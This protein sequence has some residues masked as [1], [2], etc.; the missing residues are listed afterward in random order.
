MDTNYNVD[1]IL[2][3]ALYSTEKP[4]DELINNIKNRYARE[5]SAAKNAGM[6]RPLRFVTAII[7]ALLVTSVTALAVGTYLGGFDRLRE[8]LG[9]EQVDKLHAVEKS[10][11]IGE[12]LTE[13]G[14]RIE[15][16]AVGVDS[17]AIDFYFTL[18]DLISNRLDGDIWINATVFPVVDDIPWGTHIMFPEV[19]D[20]SVDGVVTL[21]GR[22]E[23]AQPIVGQELQF[24]IYDISYN[25]KSG[26]YDT[27]IDLAS[28]EYFAP[29]AWYH[30]MPILPPNQYIIKPEVE[31]IETGWY[32]HISSIG[33]IEGQ[34]HIQQYSDASL[35][36]PPDSVDF[37]LIDPN[38]ERV[39]FFIDP[40]WQF[41]TPNFILDEQ[42]NINLLYEQ[43]PSNNEVLGRYSE[44]IYEV[45][46]ERLSEYNLVLKYVKGDQIDLRIW[47]TVFEIH[48]PDES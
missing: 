39:M 46:L 3:E 48:M 8:V 28:L 45:D 38:G 18:E 1:S 2:K 5:R 9:G 16:V 10:N 37:Q 32:G 36:N 20:R 31:V 15:V 34:L 12:L 43:H 6:R 23:F 44:Y 40:Q 21:R 29:A 17:H 25:V 42:G 33:I 24:N 22:Q 30:D 35:W 47:S 27:G 26:E 14:I 4:T 7:A 13:E 41:V 19:I 11:V